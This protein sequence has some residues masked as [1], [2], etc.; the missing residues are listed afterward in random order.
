MNLCTK[1]SHARVPDVDSIDRPFSLPAI[2][3]Q[4]E[5]LMKQF[6]LQDACILAISMVR[7]TNKYL[8]DKAPWH[9]KG[10][11]Q[12][13]EVVV[14]TILES[15]YIAAHFLSPFIPTTCAQIFDYLSTPATTL[16]LL[17]PDFANLQPGTTVLVGNILFIKLLTEEDRAKQQQA[18]TTS[19]EKKTKT[20]VKKKVKTELLVFAALDLRVGQITRVWPHTE[21]SA[22]F[23]A[24]VDV[25]SESDK[26]QVAVSLTGHYTAESLVDRKV[27][28]LCNLKP[29]KIEGFKSHA[30]V[31]CGAT[32]EQKQL[33]L[34]E[35]PASAV[36]GE[37]VF[38]ASE[39]GE[40]VSAGQMKKQKVWE[41]ALEVLMTS[42]DGV[43]MYR[44][45]VIQTSTGPCRAA[46]LTNVP[47]S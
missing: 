18:L 2:R 19:A 21:S 42:E 47:M 9:M 15:I 20:E 30:V 27:L 34:I 1:Y 6:A 36:N 8:T 23:C 5:K 3:K 16:R 22:H 40:P 4:M 7:D 44:D 37:R 26:L 46:T 25:G 45:Q 31:L 43:A 11:P 14:R 33:E 38:V 28:V 39:S 13:Q 32:D 10:D 24:E 35:P 17:S 12:G 41:K 29:V